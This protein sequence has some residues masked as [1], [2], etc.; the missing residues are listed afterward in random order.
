MPYTGM[1]KPMVVSCSGGL[2]LY[3][4]AFAMQPGRALPLQNF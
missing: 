4:D 2:D 3:K 1:Q